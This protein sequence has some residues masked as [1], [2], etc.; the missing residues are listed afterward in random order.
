MRPTPSADI[1]HQPILTIRLAN[2]FV[3]LSGPG[4]HLG[5]PPAYRPFLAATPTDHGPHAGFHILHPAEDSSLQ[6]AS[7][8]A[9]C[10]NA[11]TWR[12][13]TCASGEMGVDLARWPDG[14]WIPTA[15]ATPDFASARIRPILGR[16]CAPAPWALNYPCDQILLVNRLAMLSATV[17]HGCGVSWGGRGCLLCGRS[18]VGKTT[19]GRLCRDA[20]AVL[21]NDDRMLIRRDE[22]GLVLAATPWHGAEEAVDA[23]PSGL[24]AILLLR[25]A[26]DVELTRLPGAA[27]AAAL[28]S[29]CVAPFYSGERLSRI[30]DTVAAVC[31][32]VPVYRLSFTPTT[33]AAETVRSLAEGPGEP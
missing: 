30:I 15:N 12:M 7:D 20:G 3:R 4:V 17:L 28:L 5:V 25:Q 29:N 1:Q 19:L 33:K 32:R 10:W 26:P 6:T 8:A 2:V 18:G 27:A 31:E 9:L 21:M 14:K 22:G 24:A 13:G 16:L 11:D 23:T